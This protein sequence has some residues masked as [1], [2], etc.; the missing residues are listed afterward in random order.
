MTDL[1]AEQFNQDPR[2]EKA[3]HLLKDTLKSYQTKLINVRGP[4]LNKKVEYEALI[5]ECSKLRGGN[6]YYP[7][8]SS[9]FG[10]GAL[11]ELTDGS[12]KYDLI[13]GIGVHY[14]G[15][16]HP[17]LLEISIR[18]SLENTIMQGNLQQNASSVKLLK[19]FISI[20]RSHGA[21]LDH[22]FLSTSGT[23]ANENALKL[24]FHKKDG[25]AK[26]IL[27][28]HHC[29]AGRTMVMGQITDKAEYRQG[30]PTV[31]DVD[32]IPFYDPKHP[33][34]STEA[35]IHSL[36]SHLDNHPG[37][38]AGMIFEL[39]QGEGGYYPGTHDFFVALMNILKTNDIAII[40]DEIQSFGRMSKPFAFQYFA[41]DDYIDVVTVGKMT[42]VCATLFT[43]EYKPKSGLLSQTFTASTAA[44]HVAQRTLERLSDAD[45]IGENGKIAQ[46]NHYFVSA[47]KELAD[48]TF[49]YS[50]Q[51][52]YGQDG[53]IACTVFDGS[54][55]K[56]KQFLNTL[57]DNGVIAFIT[58]KNPARIRFLLPILAI[59]K[60]DIDNAAAIIG[61]T[62]KQ[63]SN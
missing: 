40:I 8:L 11:V 14:W 42:Q 35:A 26:R 61:T 19:T 34:T 41:L 38:Y 5:N 27:A 50:I 15:H 21:Q 23:M 9:G 18:A 43:S 3:I 39:I 16:S 62:L 53:M 52:P 33:K 4:V 25:N 24:V 7:Y 29:F 20:A 63:L 58:G 32:Y 13:T 49:P 47:L 54:M 45:Y 22:C 51:G 56:T 10:N 31:L 1:L 59:D 57:F 12:I 2:I 48:T 6:L 44:I 60:N 46:L 55:E 17:E 37:E 28:F 36:K 30:L